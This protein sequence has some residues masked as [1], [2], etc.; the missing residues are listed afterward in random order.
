MT[1]A[2]ANGHAP[3]L[4]AGSFLGP[5]RTAGYVRETINYRYHEGQSGYLTIYDVDEM[6][7]DE[8]V[9]LGRYTLRA[10]VYTAKWTVKADKPVASFVDRMLKK[11]WQQDIDKALGMLEWGS[12]GGELTY[13]TN[14]VNG[15]M[16]YNGFKDIYIGDMR[17]LESPR[18]RQM[19]GLRVQNISGGSA[20]GREPDLYHPR[21]FWV[22]NEARWGSHYG[23]SRLI[24]AKDPWL[25]KRGKHGAVANRTL[26][27]VKNSFGGGVIRFPEGVVEAA[28]G[29]FKSNYEIARELIEQILAGGNIQLPSTRDP[30]TGQYLWEYIPP[31]INGDAHQLLDYPDKL[32]IAIL[33]G[34]GVPPEVVQ[35]ATVGGGWSGRS[36]PMLLFLASSDRIVDC[37]IRAWRRCIGDPL[38]KYNYGSEQY[39]IEPEPLAGKGGDQPQGGAGAAPPPAAPEQIQ[40]PAQDG[41]QGQDAAPPQ[42]DQGGT[43]G[44]VMADSGGNPQAMMGVDE[45]QQPAPLSMGPHAFSSTQL[46]L[47]PE[48][49]SLIL[50][51][52]GRV[53]PRDLAGDGIERDVHSTVL[54]GLHGD[55]PEPVRQLV[56]GFG[57]VRIRLGEISLFPAKEAS[58]QRGGDAYDVVKIDVDSPDLHRLHDLLAKLPHTKT[59]P[60]YVSHITLLYCKPG[61]GAKYAGTHDLMGREIVFDKLV[62]SPAS[63]TPSEIRLVK[64]A[65]LSFVGREGV[66]VMLRMNDAGQ[67]EIYR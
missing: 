13:R 5:M 37:L 8:Q 46:N 27:A 42:P 36:V 12:A 59:H 11:F 51:M 49:S 6:L 22:A 14:P 63:G 29:V 52:A 50:D 58:S 45:D 54:Y 32:D 61:A 2:T 1:T 60:R 39:E 10:P 9:A 44:D 48:I 67:I 30:Q 31:A 38:V 53:D 21:C 57:P 64:P 24:A 18:D 47:P 56:E 17:V 34:M 65:A 4:T 15:Q 7:R 43:M 62:Y 41:G 20:F 35:A 40:P 33:K 23:R 19:V 66:Q 3:K 55:D 26:W 28:E 25:E 16:E